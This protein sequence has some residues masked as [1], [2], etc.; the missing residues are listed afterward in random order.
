MTPKEK[1]EELF[2]TFSSF[3]NAMLCVDEILNTIFNEDF[4]GHLIDEIGA[5]DYW[6]EVKTEIEK[7]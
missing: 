2:K 1:A 7:L 6:K 5:S 3:G 4:S